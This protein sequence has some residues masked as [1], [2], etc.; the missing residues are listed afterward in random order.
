MQTDPSPS[1]LQR[2]A[3]FRLLAQAFAIPDEDGVHRLRD[4]MKR[5]ERDTSL[6]SPGTRLWFTRA[7][8]AWRGA[9]V[10]RVHAEYL[11]LFLGKQEASL[12]ETAYGDGRRM[13]GREAELADLSG[14]YRA[15]GFTLATRD[16]DLPDHVSVELEFLS[17]L[18]AKEAYAR[19]TGSM[20]QAQITAQAIKTFLEQHLGRWAG[21]LREAVET[22]YAASPFY[23]SAVLL[24]RAVLQE[25]RVRHARP[26]STTDRLPL[27]AVTQGEG[28]VCP[29]ES[30]PA[31][32]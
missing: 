28:F 26:T 25:C 19:S 22:A 10:D 8:R 32:V 20:S 21:V 24:E 15:F 7:A 3:L 30:V 6:T 23:E 1:L 27:D 16:P 2:A 14:F 5:I 31:G 12:H 4:A 9:E 17:L 29:H 18:Q 13:A 11:R